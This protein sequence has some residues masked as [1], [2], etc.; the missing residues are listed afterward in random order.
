VRSLDEVV[1]ILARFLRSEEAATAVEYAV[2]L[3]V[4]MTALVSIAA[5]GQQTSTMYDTIETEMQS[6]G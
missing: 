4:I 2:V 6:H 3:V 5:L 1:N